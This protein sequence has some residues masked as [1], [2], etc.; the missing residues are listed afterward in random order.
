MGISF[1][2]SRVFMSVIIGH[3]ERDD[4]WFNLQ[5]QRGRQLFERNTGVGH[6]PSKIDNVDMATDIFYET[7]LH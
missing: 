4:R 1:H 3:I 5:W 7:L 6:S 2:G